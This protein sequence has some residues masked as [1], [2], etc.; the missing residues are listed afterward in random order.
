M[1]RRWS[2]KVIRMVP[3]GENCWMWDGALDNKHVAQHFAKFSVEP[4]F[5]ESCSGRDHLSQHSIPSSQVP[6]SLWWRRESSAS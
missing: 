5:N 3:V 6:I 1:V 2:A 4:F